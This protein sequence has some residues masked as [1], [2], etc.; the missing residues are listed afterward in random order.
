MHPRTR[1]LASLGCLA[2]VGLLVVVAQFGLSFAIDTKWHYQ[3]AHITSSGA[4]LSYSYNLWSGVAHLWNDGAAPLAV[5][6]LLWSGVWPY[7]KLGVLMRVL[8]RADAHGLPPWTGTLSRLGRWSLLDVWVVA[9]TALAVRV[10]FDIEHT[11]VSFFGYMPEKL[12]LKIWSQAVALPGVYWF[13]TACVLSQLCGHEFLRQA[14]EDAA[15]KGAAAPS[16]SAAATA[17]A[18][19]TSDGDRDATAFR[20]CDGAAELP[21]ASPGAARRWSALVV[22]NAA[23]LVVTFTALPIVSV[24]Y[25]LAP[26]LHQDIL[27]LE[28]ST[29][30]IVDLDAVNGFTFTTA[31]ALSTVGAFNGNTGVASQNYAMMGAAWLLV[32][33]VP[34]ARSLALAAMWLAPLTRAWHARLHEAAKLCSLVASHDLFVIALAVMTWQLPLLWTRTSAKTAEESGFS[35]ASTFLTMGMTPEFGFVFVAASVALDNFVAG[36]VMGM[37]AAALAPPGGAYGAVGGAAA[38]P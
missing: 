12:Y 18:T 6:V 13:L 17:T 3:V 23:L 2:C 1:R 26:K 28:L 19:P 14:R 5:V 30:S 7:V 32:A 33:V 36:R 34:W 35:A 31:A 38:P 25:H 37:H 10:S 29:S 16:G 24:R 27:G 4:G 22:A 8:A 20:G 21:G 11:L 15:R 9:V